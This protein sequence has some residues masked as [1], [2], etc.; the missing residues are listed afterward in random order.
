MPNIITPNDDGKNEYFEPVEEQNITSVHL[1]VYNRWGVL[2]F[3][4]KDNTFDWQAE[5][6]QDGLY[7]YKMDHPELNNLIKGWVEVKR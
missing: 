4:E 7:Y 1:S 2:V 3:E 6:L 5:G